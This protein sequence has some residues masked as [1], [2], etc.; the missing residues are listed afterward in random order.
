MNTILTRRYLEMRGG[1]IVERGRGDGRGQTVDEVTSE[2]RVGQGGLQVVVIT[3]WG[4]CLV[5]EGG[6]IRANK[7]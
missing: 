6:I 4:R 5:L 3:E 2:L 7:Y 1:G